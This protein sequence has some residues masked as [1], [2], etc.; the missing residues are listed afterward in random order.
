M[1]GLDTPAPFLRHISSPSRE[2]HGAHSGDL[3]AELRKSATGTP[4]E[5]E[6]QN[7]VQKSAKQPVTGAARRG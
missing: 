6:V 2:P 4:P 5:Q 3:L 1:H 7:T